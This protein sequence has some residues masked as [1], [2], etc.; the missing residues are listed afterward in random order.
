VDGD[1]LQPN[2]KNS[3]NFQQMLDLGFSETSKKFQLL[4]NFPFIVLA[5]FSIFPLVP[6]GNNEKTSSK[7]FSNYTR[8]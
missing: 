6:L 3:K 1:F 8:S 7:K 2:E 5:F 4:N